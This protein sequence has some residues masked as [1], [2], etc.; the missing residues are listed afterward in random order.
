[1]Q[2]HHMI[3]ADSIPIPHI[4]AIGFSDDPHITHF[5]P[6]VRN[7]YIIHYILSGS[8]F[9]NGHRLRRGEGFLITP[10]LHE[11]YYPDN[12]DPWSFIWV[13]SEDPAMQYFFDRYGANEQTGIFKINDLY[14]LFP[15]AEKLK[16]V[17]DKPSSSTLLA[18]TFLQSFHS[19][20]YEQV[21][22]RSVAK[23][24]VDFSVNYIKVNLHL[25]LNVTDL[26]EKLGVSQPYLYRIFK[27]ETGC[28]PKQYILSRK[29]EHAKTLLT[30]TN[31]TVSRISDSVGF[32]D[33]LEFSK[34]FSKQT[35]LSP[36]AYRKKHR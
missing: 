3:A 22:N 18:E 6:S 1:M 13:I 31:F 11:E 10:G 4:N 35:S 5:G 29:L 16:T 34:F 7:Q 9:F 24:Y 30:Q 17:L 2:K 23:I 25:P 14:S 21:K 27:Q 32:S 12:D 26:C 20:T 36:T 19:C 33:V 28:S 15:I 8:G